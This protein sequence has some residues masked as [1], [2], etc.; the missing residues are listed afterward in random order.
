MTL[1]RPLFC[2]LLAAGLFACAGGGKPGDEQDSAPKRTVKP[3]QVKDAEPRWEP[4]SRYG[5]RPSY[6]VLGKT[7]TV[8]DSAAGY[9]QTGIASWYGS[10]FHGRRTSSGEVFDMYQATAAHRSLP[11]PTY[12]EVTNLDNGKKVIVKINDR[13]PF[14][15]GRLIDLS[16]GA[17]VKIGMADMGT[18]R[19]EVR[20]VTF[21]EEDVRLPKDTFLQAGA[22][23]SK[24]SAKDLAEAL[25]DGDVKSVDVEK[26]E[27]WY[28]VLV[29]PFKKSSELNETVS[30]IVELGYERPHKVRR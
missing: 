22:F 14:H 29:G 13:G 16:Y 5:N 28:R 6:E 27:G 30:H 25:E 20:A 26:S 15:S 2:A 17:A 10:K 4:R 24:S 23:R 7:Y 21:D 12:A 9:R 1:A 8:M 11:L 3:S 19:V 18:G